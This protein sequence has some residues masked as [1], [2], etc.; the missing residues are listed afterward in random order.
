MKSSK[1]PSYLLS[2][3]SKVKCTLD[4]ILAPRSGLSFKHPFVHEF[5]TLSFA[6]DLISQFFHA[7]A[8]GCLSQ[9]C[10]LPFVRGDFPRLSDGR[11]SVGTVSVIR[12]SGLLFCLRVPAIPGAYRF[13]PLLL[14]LPP[15]MRGFYIGQVRRAAGVRLGTFL[16]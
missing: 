2:W 3:Q 8:S 4:C 15:N 7:D 10:S 14:V 16:C 6:Q 11:G 5:V 13:C 9:P 12:A 1:S